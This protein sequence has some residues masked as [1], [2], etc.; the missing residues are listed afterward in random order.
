MGERENPSG[1][2]ATPRVL[3]LAAAVIHAV[4]AMVHHNKGPAALE[5]HRRGHYSSPMLRAEAR[6]YLRADTTR[7]G[8]PAEKIDKDKNGGQKKADEKAE[9]RAKAKAPKVISKPIPSVNRTDPGEMLKQAKKELAKTN[10]NLAAA[11]A[12]RKQVYKNA[13]RAQ[14]ALARG[15]GK[16]KGKSKSESKRRLGGTREGHS[17][18]VNDKLQADI[19]KQDEGIDKMEHDAKSTEAALDDRRKARAEERDWRPKWMGHHLAALYRANAGDDFGA[20]AAGRIKVQKAKHVKTQKLDI[21]M[22]QLR[23]R[24]AAAQHKH[25]EVVS[26]AND[27]RADVLV[28][29][30]INELMKKH[31][32]MQRRKKQQHRQYHPHLY[33]KGL[34][35]SDREIIG[36]SNHK[37]QNAV[38]V[39]QYIKRL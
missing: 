23:A 21:E 10:K 33:G 6:L 22:K 20:Q 5:G 4:V 39:Q 36:K 27:L 8:D 26:K 24:M 28:G 2:R 7:L 15:K 34:T 1:M 13:K 32:A 35:Q 30:E 25:K 12:H 19:E 18:E 14:E 9:D 31:E 37:M 3:L 38:L 29:G 17:E 11:R 16:G